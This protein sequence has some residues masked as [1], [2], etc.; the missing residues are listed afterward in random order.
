MTKIEGKLFDCLRTRLTAA[1]QSFAQTNGLELRVEDVSV[2]HYMTD[3]KVDVALTL[4]EGR[5]EEA[6]SV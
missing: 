5:K 6:E 4:R 2:I 3:S 1:I